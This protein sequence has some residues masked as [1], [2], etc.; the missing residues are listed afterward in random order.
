[1]AAG[2]KTA[3]VNASDVPATLTDYP[4]YVDLSRLGIT[5]LAE[6]ESV[7]VYADSGKTTEW[8]REIVS[9]TEMHVKVPSLTSST[10][11]YVDWDG[12]RADYA[13]SATY[14]AENTWNSNYSAVWHM[15]ESSGNAIDSTSN[16][17]DLTDNNTV[18][19]ATG[20]LNGGGRQ[21]TRANNESLSVNDSPLLS[22]GSNNV[23]IQSWVKMSTINQVLYYLCQKGWYNPSAS[24]RE[25]N[26]SIYTGVNPD[27]VRSEVW[28]GSFQNA[29]SGVTFSVG[30]W[31]SWVFRR[32]G[33]AIKNIIN[34]TT[35]GTDTVGTCIDGSDPFVIGVGYNSSG[36]AAS[37]DNPFDGIVDEFRFSQ[38]ALSDDWLTTEY[39]NQSD[40]SGFWGTWTDAGGGGGATFIPRVSIIS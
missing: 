4:A 10:V 9:A 39:N 17:L 40:E 11:I 32:D 12:V 27:A 26:M 30:T 34:N 23:T 35:T 1:M 29:S 33:S 16:G 25:F 38:T 6:A 8:A 2:F 13:T 15:N 14:G 19:S 31:Y 3:T 22:L 18:T 20:K 21:F 28:D 36:P 7:R 5:T 37:S 24:N